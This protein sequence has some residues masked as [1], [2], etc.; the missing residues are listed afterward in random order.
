MKISIYTQMKNETNLVGPFI[1]HCF[2]LGFDNIYIYDDQSSIPLTET[3][4]NNQYISKINI[5]NIDFTHE[6]YVN[7]DFSSSIFY[8]KNLYNRWNKNR[9]QYLI[10]FFINKHK[11]E[12]EWV[13]FCDVDEFLYINENNIHNYLEKYLNKYADMSCI[14]FQ[15]IMFGTSFHSYFPEDK[16]IYSNFTWSTN[17][18]D[19]FG[20][21]LININDIESHH[22]HSA[23]VKN[24]IYVPNIKNIHEL[25]TI[26]EYFNKFGITF[27]SSNSNRRIDFDINCLNAFL[28][29]Y[30][31]CDVHTFF[32]RKYV[33]ID[34]AF[35]IQ[36]SK[37]YMGQIYSFNEQEVNYMLK[38]SKFNFEPQKQK[39]LNLE[40]YN[41]ENKTN[42]TDFY[43]VI[44]HFY[45]NKTRCVY[46]VFK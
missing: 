7:N 39:F 38:Y 40:K 32:H 34:V 33:L 18:L 9:Q 23:V 44:E 22:I 6:Q 17:K 43:D 46:Y 1:N 37:S 35:S 2:N 42:F 16:D 13:F 12:L 11:S 26:E 30:V 5:Y 24:K 4:K 8:D 15:W 20:K 29:H 19:S 31:T 36:R 14:F 10:N 45:L 28:A 41:N 27:N 3:L 21:S 25:L